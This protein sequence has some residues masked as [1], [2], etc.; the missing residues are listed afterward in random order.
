MVYEPSMLT[1]VGK[2]ST[3]RKSS[4]RV[5][6]ISCCVESKE[7]RPR[8]FGSVAAMHD[9][10]TSSRWAA[11][12]HLQRN[13]PV[14]N[15]LASKCSRE[16][17]VTQRCKVCAQ[18]DSGEQSLFAQCMLLGMHVLSEYAVRSTPPTVDMECKKREVALLR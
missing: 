2:S 13:R 7:V 14:Q 16:H 17:T 9:A 4:S 5:V 10:H 1:A 12:R 3:P 6:S 11:M 15:A 18:R 8:Q